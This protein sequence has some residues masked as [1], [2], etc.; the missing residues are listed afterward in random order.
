VAR[1]ALIGGLIGLLL[2][3]AL[4]AGR[5]ASLQRRVV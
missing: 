3:L 4:A 1:G 2:G 5:E